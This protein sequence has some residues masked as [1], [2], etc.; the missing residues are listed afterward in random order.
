MEKQIHSWLGLEHWGLE[1]V[2]EQPDQDLRLGH[3]KRTQIRFLWFLAGLLTIFLSSLT[4]EYIRHLAA[5]TPIRLG[6]VI[7]GMVPGV[8]GLVAMI[9]VSVAFVR[10]V[11]GIYRSR[12]AFRYVWLLLFGRAPQALL[13]L[14]KRWI[15][16]QLASLGL[17]RWRIKPVSYPHLTV[18][19]GQIDQKYQGTLMADLGGPGIVVI[20]SD[21]AVVLERFGR[22]IRFAGPGTI[23][24]RR[25]ERIREVL[26]LRPQ[27]RTAQVRALT[28]EGLPVETEV[29]VRFQLARDRNKPFP[30]PPGTLSPVYRWAW[31]RA[32]QCH[33]RVVNLDDGSEREDGWPNRVMGNVGSTLRALLA[34]IELDGL[35]EPQNTDLD[36]RQ[37]LIVEYKEK[38]D[39]AARNFGAEI[40]DVRM[41]PIK[42]ALPQIEKKRI[43]NWR[44]IQKVE[45]QI[46]E[47][48]GEAEAIRER[49]LARAYA[50]MEIILSLTREFQEALEKDVALPAEF[51]SLRF[52]EAL[53]LAWSQPGGA[54]IS[55][56]ALRT[57]DRL[58][59]L[60]ET[61]D[62]L[63]SGGQEYSPVDKQSS[64]RQA[65]SHSAL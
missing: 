62:A 14:L 34:D 64:E 17:P 27:E 24:L 61:P 5:Q 65:D 53:R 21:S 49:G 35:I 47:A 63:T 33:R 56:E 25:F 6:R 22:F 9:C 40:L 7:L 2:Q 59:K 16:R 30:P 55:S 29:Q 42:P 31:S 46:E 23:F 12:E 39:D 38:L 60:V 26:D 19:E 11:Y 13:E 28:K 44:A 10:E 8:L 4:L 1:A 51:I 32:S 54:F 57:L 41:G 52:I 50:Q 48:H 36:P 20:F 43:A 58:Q 18:H 37:D 15:N 3:L 45:S